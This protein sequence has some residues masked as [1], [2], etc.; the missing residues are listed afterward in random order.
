MPYIGLHLGWTTNVSESDG[1]KYR[2]SNGSTGIHGGLKVFLGENIS[3]NIELDRTSYT[4]E[5]ESGDEID[6]DVT[7]LFAGFS[8][9]F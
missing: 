8:Y 5:Y 7:T 2:D 1:D 9:Y 3:W 4:Y 6:I